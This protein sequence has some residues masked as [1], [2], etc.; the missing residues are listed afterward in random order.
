VEEFHK[1]W[2]RQVLICRT[3]GQPYYVTYNKPHHMKQ[4]L[5]YALGLCVTVALVPALVE[6]LHRCYPAFSPLADNLSAFYHFFYMLGGLGGGFSG[7][8]LT[9]L[10]YKERQA[11]KAIQKAAATDSVW[12]RS[13]LHLQSRSALYH[14]FHAW[15]L[16]DFSLLVDVATDDF[17]KEMAAWG[18]PP[19]CLDPHLVNSVEVTETKIVACDDY[20]DDEKD[21]YTSLISGF[22]LSPKNQQ[23]VGYVEVDKTP[24]KLTCTFIRVDSG[25]RLNEMN[26]HIT[27]GSMLALS[28]TSES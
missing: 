3:E 19:S 6:L 26:D 4:Y 9:V 22:F 21:S 14:V 13:D 25:W 28:S 24:F 17:L 7:I 10:L 23:A 15:S 27:L 11:A 18:Q 5:S 16:Q 2:E 12:Q 20:L 8:L 1:L